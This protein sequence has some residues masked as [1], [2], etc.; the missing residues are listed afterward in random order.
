MSRW[1]RMYD[2]IVDDPKVQRLPD[3]LF[4]AWVNLLCLASRNKGILPSVDDIAFSLRSDAERVAGW[5]RDLCARGLIDDEDGETKP[6]NWQARQFKSDADPTAAERQARKRARDAEERATLQ[7][8][9][10]PSRGETHIVTP[11][12]SHAVTRDI[13]P[14]RDRAETETENNLPPPVTSPAKARGGGDLIDCIERV[15]TAYP[16]SKTTSQPKAL[17]AIEATPPADWPA[18]IAGCAGY[19]AEFKDKPTT[20]P[21]ALDRFIRERIFDNFSGK[22]SADT[23]ALVT[24][25]HD[26]PEG[27][28]WDANWRATKGKPPPWS[29][30]RWYFPT[31]AP[32]ALHAPHNGFQQ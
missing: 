5:L 7:I 2:E 31:P 25:L 32:P 17:A 28:A 10:Q 9:H 27:R 21:I 13:T 12:A 19:A 15:L 6:H 30:G 8:T 1:F 4:K 11:A 18:L 14:S 16:K 24:V 3:A 22:P 20:H 26:T 29:N 23:A